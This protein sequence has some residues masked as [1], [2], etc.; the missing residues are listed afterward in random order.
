MSHQTEQRLQQFLASGEDSV[1]LQVAA[2]NTLGAGGTFVT[3]VWLGMHDGTFDMYDVG[4]AASVGVER[5]AED[6]EIGPIAQ[7]FQAQQGT[8]AVGGVIMGGAGAAGPLDPGETAST[9]LVVADPTDARYLVFLTMVIPSNDAFLASPDD[10]LALAVFDASGEF[11]GE[12]TV[13]L[14]GQDVLDA[15]TEANTEMDAAFINQTAPNTGV[16]EGGVIHMHPGF[17]GSVGNPDGEPM[18]ILGGTT[19]AGT[20]VDPVVGDFTRG[21]G[22]H[23]VMRV[24]V[25]LAEEGAAGAQTIDAGRGD[26]S[27]AGG[28]GDDDL[29]GDRGDDRLRG[30]SGDDSLD[31]GR[32]DDTLSGGL[33]DDTLSGERGDDNLHGGV[34]DDWLEGGRGTDFL[35]GGVGVNQLT[36]DRDGDIFVL[37][38]GIDTVTD[39][40][41]GDGDR[42]ALANGVDVAAALAAVSQGATG[43]MIDFGGGSSV[44]LAGV[45]A[46]QLTAAWFLA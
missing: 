27:L 29:M 13:V 46:N 2:T 33:G 17:N 16:T 22:A 3:P 26:D 40:D 8:G 36:G 1:R 45:N 21:G 9:T 38:G 4:A 11:N 12:F 37:Q 42:L 25:R 14:R 5:V 20:V 35:S 7:A 41:F 39:F 30:E 31:G 32:G 43:A 44:T 34:G 15:G 24:T 10:P 23:E 6:G 28:A 18:I 19:A